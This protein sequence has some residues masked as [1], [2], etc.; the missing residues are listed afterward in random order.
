[1]CR[2]W[3]RL[4]H[5]L[6]RL[7]SGKTSRFFGYDVVSTRVSRRTRPFLVRSSVSSSA[8]THSRSLSPARVL[9]SVSV[10]VRRHR[11]QK[12]NER[13]GPLFLGLTIV[14][15]RVCMCVCT[16]CSQ[17]L[18]SL[19]SYRIVL[20]RLPSRFLA[21]LYRCSLSAIALCRIVLY[22]N[23]LLS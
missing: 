1:M 11:Y 23:I 6:R 9:V 15:S 8:L 17:A 12:E 16:R 4:F 19:V 10:L 14:R 21:A 20:S 3:C 2:G 13:A 7:S 18:L 22:H 5:G